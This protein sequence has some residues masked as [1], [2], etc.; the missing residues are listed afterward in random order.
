MNGYYKCENGLEYKRLDDKKPASM[1]GFFAV[2]FYILQR[3]GKKGTDQIFSPMT[4]L[5]DVFVI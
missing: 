1:A 3:E 4:I 2:Y 5:E